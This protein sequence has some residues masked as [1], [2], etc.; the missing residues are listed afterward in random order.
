ME[1]DINTLYDEFT[2]ASDNK[3]ESLND[4]KNYIISC[5]IYLKD[6]I[7]ELKNDIRKNNVFKNVSKIIGKSNFFTNIYT[8]EFYV[9]DNEIL[10]EALSNL[11]LFSNYL[12]RLYEIVTED[13]YQE[14]FKLL[15]FICQ[16]QGE[17]ADYINYLRD[18]IEYSMKGIS[19][20]DVSKNSYTFVDRDFFD[21]KIKCMI[22]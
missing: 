19:Y 2:V 16:C 13:N 3:V 4:T 15:S 14:I 1:K 18:K 9:S 5:Y 10:N 8:E 21:E 7:K 22:K 20:S 11:K 17:Y 6:N 12:L